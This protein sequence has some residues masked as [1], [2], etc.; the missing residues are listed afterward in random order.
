MLGYHPGMAVAAHGV[1]G[2]RWAPLW[3][4]LATV[5]TSE[6]RERTFR[7]LRDRLLRSD[8]ELPRL[9]LDG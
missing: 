5:A 9:E 2:K 8:L 6:A 4:V 3:V 1:T 7:A